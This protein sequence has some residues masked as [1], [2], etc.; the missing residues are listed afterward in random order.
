MKPLALLL[1]LTSTSAMAQTRLTVDQYMAR[2]AGGTWTINTP[3]EPPYGIE[4]Y[5]ADN[6]VSWG[7]L[8]T[9]QCT[10]GTWAE[11]APRT[12]CY[13]YEGDDRLH[14]WQY[15]EEDGNLFAVL[16]DAQGKDQGEPPYELVETTLSLPCVTE[17]LGS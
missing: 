16:T 12:I 11:A 10:D 9:G 8:E 5:R 6:R 7:W 2:V 15:F 17:F 3:G 1:I 4:A 13:E 14:C